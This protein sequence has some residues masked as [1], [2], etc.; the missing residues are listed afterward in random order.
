M[1]R[2]WRVGLELPAVL[3]LIINNRIRI[4]TS[5]QETAPP[6]FIIF[7]A[8]GTRVC[9]ARIAGSSQTGPRLCA[10]HA[11]SIFL[12]GGFSRINRLVV[13]ARTLWE[14]E[15]S[16]DLTDGAELA[17]FMPFLKNADQDR[18]WRAGS[19]LRKSLA[20]KRTMGAP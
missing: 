12:K 11:A 17:W 3:S 19:R 1:D 18:L 9:A 8:N 6:F 5:R 16:S 20:R 2:G 10:L 7:C 13:V 15:I 4:Y 14:R